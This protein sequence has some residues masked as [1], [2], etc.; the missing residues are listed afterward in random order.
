MGGD[1]DIEKGSI[2]MKTR[3]ALL[4]ISALLLTQCNNFIHELI[5]QAPDEELPPP[6]AILT[7]KTTAPETAIGVIDQAKRTIRIT[8]PIGT[9]VTGMTTDIT[10]LPTAATLSLSRTGPTNFSRSVRYTVSDGG[11]S[12]TY[13]V[14]VTV[15]AAL[16]P[17]SYTV[18]FDKNNNDAGS[19]EANPQMMPV[20]GGRTINP[21]S[22]APAR[23]GYS[24]AGWNGAA[25]GSGAAF[26]E[27][28]TV[29]EN[30]TV[31]AQ[32]TVNTYTVT[33]NKNGGDTDA[34]PA[35]NTTTYG[36]TVS[37][38]PTTAPGW[39]GHT[40][41]GWWTE[42]GDNGN[43]GAAFTATTTVTA[44]II[45][46]A[47]W[48]PPPNYYTVTFNKNNS[49][50]GSTEANP[51][52]AVVADNGTVNPLP[53]QPVRTGY[54]F[55]GWWTANGSVGNWG[56][57]FT[58]STL[59]M[60]NI[61]VYAKWTANIY[62]VTFDKNGGTTEASPPTKIVTVPAI[63]IDALPTTVPTWASHTF[64]GW[65]TE[66]GDSGNWGTEFTA[67]TTVTQN[68][69]VY[70]KWNPPPN[71][72]MVTFDKN[73]TDSGS[74]EAN[75]Q[76]A[77]VADGGT[78]NPLPAQ[79]VRTGYTF[80]G[81]WTANGSG[82]NWGTEFTAST[83]VTGNITVYAQWTINTYTVT[84][85]KNGGDTEAD[86]A[87][88]AVAAGNTVN[89][90][91]SPPARTGYTFG[92]WN[93]AA[94]GSGTMFDAATTVT[95]DITVYAKWTINTYTVTFNK[96]GGDTEASP[97]SK[98]ATHGE[99]VSLPTT[100]PTWTDHTF[101]GWYESADGGVTPG[102]GFT[103]ATVVT[104]NITVYAQW[105]INTYT[106]TFDK[107]NTDSGSTEASPNTLGP[108]TH[109]G[110][111]SLPTTD[112]AR[113]GYTFGGW[114]TVANG[115]GTVFDA[116]TT[117]MADITVYAQWTINNYTVI[118]DKNG[119]DTE[120]SPASA[121]TTYGGTVSLP[122]TA[123]TWASHTFEGWWTENGDG[124]N[125]GVP[126]IASAPVTQNI[127][128]YAKWNPP[129][130]YYTV[131]FNKNGGDTEADPNTAEVAA[132]NMV[133]PLPI[134]PVRTGY[135]FGGWNT[136]ANGSGTVFDATTTVM[137]DITLYA[138]WT[139]NTYTVTFDKN[140]GDTDASPT[141][142][143]TTYG[144]TVSLPTQPTK[145][146]YTFGGW[147][148]ST[149]G[150]VT[151][152]TEFT[153]TTTV[154]AN[155]T[156]YAKWTVNTYTVT[157][158]KQSG[159]GG[160]DSVTASYGAAMPGATAPSR[161][162]YAFGGYWTAVNGGGTQYYTD[163]MVSARNW[164]LTTATTLYAKWENRVLTVTAP[165]FSDV[166]PG[167]AQ[168]AAEGIT[169]SNS[170]NSTALISNVTVSPADAFTIGGSGNTVAAGGSINTWTIQ[171]K[172]A[173]ALG[174]YTA[175]ITVTYNGTGSTTATATV[176]IRVSTPP[177]T[178]YI[179]YTDGS[180]QIVPV[181]DFPNA[182]PVNS[183]TFYSF[184]FNAVSFP[185]DPILIG[186]R[187]DGSSVNL[188]F[189]ATSPYALK[190][191]D[192][193]VGGTFNGYRPIGTYDEFALINTH[194]VNPSNS[195]V[196]EA[197]LDLLGNTTGSPPPAPQN[198]IPI[199][200][201]SQFGDI[202]D[203]NGN[204]IS[205][206]YINEST[207]RIG[208]FGYSNGTLQNIHIG[209]GSSM[210]G[211]NYDVGGICG[212]NDIGGAIIACSNTGN[213]SGANSVGGICGSNIGTI[214]ACSNTGIVSGSSSYI[215]GICG[216]NGIGTITACSNAGNVS[217]AFL[218]GGIS[219]IDNGGTIIACS[220][221]GGVSGTTGVGGISGTIANYGTI[222]ACYWLERSGVNAPTFGIGVIAS[223]A[224]AAKFAN[225][226]W[227]TTGDHAQWG[228]GTGGSGGYWKSL[229]SWDGGAVT[230][231]LTGAKTE[232]PKLWWEP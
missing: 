138:K 41:E 116:T 139:A 141:S 13:L 180:T 81:W 212:Y 105:T 140:G 90:L 167:Y 91:P 171:P 148:K 10:T 79:P 164:D 142:N 87:G 108:V 31:Y 112:P 16:P 185:A 60:A 20:E 229:G 45:V 169:I 131:T 4:L 65:W 228:I 222:T 86:P 35:S 85:D 165:L 136:A 157:F 190:L 24:F 55:G 58:A 174:T 199:R 189:N 12:K 168:P 130:N 149:D 120:A 166:S 88:R 46:Y 96:N 93:T 7:F 29:A 97:A 67:S 72:Y 18:T 92:G 216:Y 48:N 57:E 56:T 193:I 209:A 214:I 152:G 117:V 23:P 150:G 159:T 53:A 210:S 231:P 122:T 40:F 33:F 143:T 196:Q 226:A 103:A 27:T 19:T 43:W 172:A 1:Y 219:G 98:T 73:N 221:T 84:F 75:P 39:T 119:G 78:V 186:R 147:Y 163:T 170:G 137:A 223:D 134:P 175:V 194:T 204:T 213:V 3:I 14:T 218:V 224:G 109:G 161:T 34:S 76:T 181:S 160:T 123:P 50:V 132:G 220:N 153:A 177:N 71:Y 22:A 126:F 15:G 230:N 114:N 70:A 184:T 187:A 64:E 225:T 111:V 106:V 182:L 128:V 95:A 68:I 2:S 49:D 104:T 197:D 36:G 100:A 61:T 9:D 32:W 26:D 205:N 80:G 178:L 158:D 113:T 188:S 129:P 94:N 66:N 59:V 5:P 83:P 133:N 54:T 191:R 38:L 82:G 183:K 179:V 192:P 146:G 127:T 215:G 125:W 203:G 21:L 28:T 151:L 206:L 207:G 52:R 69:T 89:P 47:K 17:V 217:G 211:G 99:T 118:F 25:N 63:T 30:I 44:D 155:I 202:F 62:T 6:P 8:V 154:T 37:P 200:G 77:F 115:S 74:T 42:N 121:T 201:F 110:T 232:F 124:G 102:A 176:S 198:W 144:G 195:Y 156:V 135:T 227:P 208:L 11:I 101:V 51:Q 173:L 145:T 162:G 107:N